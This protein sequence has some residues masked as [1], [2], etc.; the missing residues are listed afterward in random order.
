MSQIQEGVDA[1]RGQQLTACWGFEE[2]AFR[3]Q[4]ATLSHQ[5]LRVEEE[6]FQSQCKW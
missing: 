6:N 2:L 5:E 1:A 4:Q 3:Q